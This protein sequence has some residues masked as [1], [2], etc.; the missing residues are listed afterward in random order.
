MSD[1]TNKRR[2]KLRRNSYQLNNFDFSVNAQSESLFNFYDVRD[3]TTDLS[4]EDQLENMDAIEQIIGQNEFNKTW[5]K[6]KNKK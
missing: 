2:S 4:I 6:F 1:R 3:N 5:N